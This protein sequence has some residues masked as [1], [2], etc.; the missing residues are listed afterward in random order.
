MFGKYENSQRKRWFI[1]LAA[2]LAVATLLVLAG[3]ALYKRL[4]TSGSNLDTE[5]SASLVQQ[6][7]QS[8]SQPVTIPTDE[9]PTRTP[10][11]GTTSDGSV[12]QPAS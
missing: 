8:P 6:P 4:H 12:E 9:Q 10:L 1:R 5:A 3:N 2:S 11:S 7:P